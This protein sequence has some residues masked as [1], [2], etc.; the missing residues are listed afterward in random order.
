MLFA[1]L[2]VT[3]PAL[4]ADSD[5]WIESRGI[6]V[7][8]TLT[9]PDA[10]SDTA[11]PLVVLVHGHGG[12]R[13]ENG[14]FAELASMLAE[15]GIASIRMD[16]PGCG[17]STEAFTH[18]NITNMLHDLES[19]TRF[20][21]Q[22]PGI[23]AR[24]V[25]MVGYSMGGRLAML[26]ASER[27]AAIALWAPVALNGKEPMID[28]FGGA[29]NYR[30]LRATATAEGSALFV[31]PWGQEQQLGERWF[32]DMERTKPLEAIGA[33]EGAVLV[34]H[35]SADNVITADNGEAA[36]EAA[37]SSIEASIILLEG[38]DHGF[39]F[40]EPDLLA[41]GVVL[42]STVDLFREQL[43]GEN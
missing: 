24:R 34:I 29:E 9:M 35:G 15:G 22:Q 6:Q 14:A 7:P 10:E 37:S 38:A 20:A 23:D 5:L 28:Y 11:A 36:R 33:Y 25:G 26:A 19:A 2:L 39:G 21:M 13:Q 12:T 1:T 18:N 31:T 40:F 8:V 41:R 42:R 27:H 30:R 3:G 16:F 43:R 4:A 17:D 32:L